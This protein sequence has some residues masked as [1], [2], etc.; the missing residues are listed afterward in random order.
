[1]L[2]NKH[3]VIG[4]LKKQYPNAD[5]ITGD[6]NTRQMIA[7]CS[8]DE[9]LTRVKSLGESQYVQMIKDQYGMPD[10]ALIEIDLQMKQIKLIGA[11][12]EKII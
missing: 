11:T 3:I 2:L 5:K 8:R 6:L 1:M 7:R 10:L 12:T 4:M 9:S